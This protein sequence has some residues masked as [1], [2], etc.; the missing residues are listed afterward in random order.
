[1]KA[2]YH[3]HTWRCNHASGDEEVYV[4]NA[5]SRGLDTLGFSDHTPY[6]FP[7]SYYSTFRMRMDQLDDYIS[8]VHSLERKYSEKIQIPLGLEAEYYPRFFKELHTILRDKGIEY[9]ILG[10]HYTNSEVDGVY[11][12]SRTADPQDLAD[13]CTNV[14][15]AMQTGLFT[16]IAHPDLINFIG[17]D[18]VYTD[19]MRRL[20]KEAAGCGIPLELN[21]LGLNTGRN[22]PN[23]TFW[24]I[25]AEENCKTVF[26]CDAHTPD[27]LLDT[28]IENQAISL[29]N[30]FGLTVLETVPLTKI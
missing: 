7:G 22:Y 14:M 12:G 16:Y 18:A 2:N 27:A 24:E 25:A 4:Q 15:E 1:M 5:I 21:F 29:A 10:Q 17:S 8:C 20:C 3:T 30:E 13:Y 6:I 11:S 26:G 28:N 19:W 9:L 23:R